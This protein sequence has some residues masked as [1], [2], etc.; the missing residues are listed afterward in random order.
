M[1]SPVGCIMFSHDTPAAKKNGQ[2]I[3]RFSNSLGMSFVFVPAGSFQMGSPHCAPGEPADETPTIIT[4]T[5]GFF[6]QTTEVTQEQW[7]AVMHDNPSFF[8]DCGKTCPVERVSWDEC[9]EFIGKLNELEGTTCYRLPTEAEWEYACK[10]E[11]AP[12]AIRGTLADTACVQDPHLDKTGWYCGNA[13]GTT[14][15]VGEKEPNALGLYDM[16]G[17]VYEWCQDWYG[18]Y[19]EKPASDYAGPAHGEAKVM[20]GGAYFYLSGHCR[21]THRRRHSP[22]FRNKYLGLRLAIT[23]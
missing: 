6:L 19:P 16:H 22:S 17:N 9:I 7:E 12:D 10:A 2:H 21:S 15:P 18:P 5:R 11:K 8:P 14:H 20:R 3:A 1:L 4:F 13:G 23:R